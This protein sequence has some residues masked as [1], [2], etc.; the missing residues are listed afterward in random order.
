MQGT[1]NAFR[2]DIRH[3][4]TSDATSWNQ[5]KFWKFVQNTVLMCSLLYT[6]TWFLQVMLCTILMNIVIVQKHILHAT[7]FANDLILY[8]VCS[9]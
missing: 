6:D 2:W 7:Y 3:K 1:T 5:T 4:L 8:D 9:V